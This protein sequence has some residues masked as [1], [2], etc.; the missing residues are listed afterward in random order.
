MTARELLADL[1]AFPILG[2]ESNLAII[3]YI[4]RYLTGF[5]VSCTRVE[6]PTGAA[7]ACLHARIGPAV[8]GGVIL[9]G[10]TDVVPVVGQSWS[11]NPFELTARAG[12]LYG[13]GSCDMKGFLACVLAAVPTYVKTALEKPIYL[14]FSFDEEV[15]CISGQ[16]L[17]EAIRDHYEEQPAYC[18]VGEPSMLQPVV[19]HKGIV[20][21]KV[22]VRGSAGHS[23]RIRSEVSA[24][25]EAARLVLWLENKMNA[26]TGAGRTDERFDPPHSSLHV[27]QL[28]GG[29]A[30]N[31]VADTAWFTVD[32]RNI[33]SDN[34]QGLRDDFAAYAKTQEHELH[35]RFAG[36]QIIVEE[37]HPLVPALDTRENDRVVE[38]IRVLSQRQELAAVAYAAEAGQF[39]NAGFATVICGPGDIAQ[40]HRADEFISE[41]QL[42]A[43][44]EMLLRLPNVLH[45]H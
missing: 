26:L 6:D 24:V 45:G 17:A 4:E 32:M 42:A 15:G 33:P 14:A 22:T 39:A 10:H 21:E 43:G 28:H 20:V 3:A 23:S 8:D 12:K 44:A 31:I 37:Y 5:G 1:V 19:A 40:A 41:A 13:R 9:S 27:G 11:T 25:H 35:K 30:H 7:K 36:A 29:T 18:I 34:L 38:F 2:G 16:L